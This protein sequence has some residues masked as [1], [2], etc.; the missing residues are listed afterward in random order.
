[1]LGKAWDSNIFHLQGLF[2]EKI[3]LVASIHSVEVMTM[4]I[5]GG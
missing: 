2:V 5:I 3:V 1:M 4:M